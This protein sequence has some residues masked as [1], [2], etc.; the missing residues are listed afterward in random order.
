MADPVRIVFLGGL[1]EIGR[2]CMA[3]EQG[4][5]DDRRILLIDCGLMFPGPDLHGIDLVLPD[6]TYLRENA[7][8]IDG[9]V[10]THGHEDHVGG[11]QF[12][13]REV[14]LPI[15]GSAL[16]LGLARN[17]IEEAGLLGRTSLNAVP[18]GGRIRIGPFDVEF[19]PVTHSVPHAHAIAVHTPQGV[20]L[21]SGDF[22]LDL[23]PVDDR[24]T[25]L[26]RIGQIAKTEGIRVLLCD[27]T[28]AEE[29]G[30]APSERSV[31]RVL[32]T[33]F[34]EHRDR[35]IITASF[36]SHLHRIQQIADAAIAGG[37]KVA[38]LGLSMR[39]NVQLGLELG[40]VHIPA[41]SFVDV[42]DLDRYAPG[43]VCV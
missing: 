10:A 17:R 39:K 37:R 32:R 25:D 12:L 7:A 9:L 41:S 20:L 4:T 8:R 23:T 3:L 6:F 36:A 40:I 29:A 43:E 35:R 33:L 30:Y 34:E 1:G 38:T 13:L 11:I 31:G 22:K 24:R 18:D 19:I 27:S 42:E 26:A 14:S 28:N 15:Y 5:G 16:T 21:H 2:N